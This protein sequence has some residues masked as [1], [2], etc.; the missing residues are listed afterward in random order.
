MTTDLE[1]LWHSHHARIAAY[2]A[3]RIVYRYG[4]DTV[5]DLVSITYLRAL[6]A[7]RNGNGANTNAEAWLFTI[8]R[9][10]MMDFYRDKQR[11]GFLDYDALEERP[12]SEDTYQDALKSVICDR[13]RGAVAQ[14]VESHTEVI[15]MRLE[16][17]SH[18]EIAEAIGTGMEA[19]KKRGERAML[20]LKIRLQDVAA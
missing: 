13:V 11:V 16:G 8:A 17:Y 3:K 2:I 5:D 1:T 10:A 15:Q 19:A 18:D 20:A 6:V 7:M 12:A 14:L 9:S 4:Q